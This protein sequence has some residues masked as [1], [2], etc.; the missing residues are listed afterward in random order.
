MVQSEI[1]SPC[2]FLIENE[3]Q[4]EMCFEAAVGLAVNDI[5][6]ALGENTK[7]AIYNHLK[8][9]YGLNQDE[10][11]RKIKTFSSA[12]E[13][14][15]GSVGKLIEIKIIE[16]LHSQY[17]DFRFAPKNGK[18]DFVEYMTCLQNRLEPKV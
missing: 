10:I 5:L 6:T 8:N 11:P 1:L 4:V 17:A 14:T 15:F 9:V 18:L 16:K 13:E 3:E 2:S 7:Q 12:I